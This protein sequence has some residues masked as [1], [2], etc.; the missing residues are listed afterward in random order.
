MQIGTLIFPRKENKGQLTLPLWPMHAGL[1]VGLDYCLDC[2]YDEQTPMEQRQ[3]FI[4]YAGGELMYL[5]PYLLELAYE[6]R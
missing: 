2:D 4:V 3:R 5:T 1:I 6:C